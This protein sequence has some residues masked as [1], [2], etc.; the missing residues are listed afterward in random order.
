[1]APN[2]LRPSSLPAFSTEGGH[3]QP[4]ERPEVPRCTRP[5][6]SC[7]VPAAGGQVPPEH[8]RRAVPGSPP[9][10]QP[11]SGPAR[12]RPQGSRP[13][14]SAGR[15]PPRREC[16]QAGR[17]RSAA[18]LPSESPCARVS[19]ASDGLRGP[20]DLGVLRLW[21]PHG[22]RATGAWLHLAV[23]DRLLCASV[24]AGLRRVSVAQSVSAFGC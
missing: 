23:I 4:T 24:S 1:M 10:V 21:S 13:G 6:T 12:L 3:R 5:G 11:P 8:T 9:L 16:S 7:P 15:W 14:A 20:H 22:R 2:L 17:G 19:N 18:P